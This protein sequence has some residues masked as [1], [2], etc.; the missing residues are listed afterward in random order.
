MLR[1]IPQTVEWRAVIENLKA[2][3]EGSLTK[4]RVARVLTERAME[5]R[6]KTGLNSDEPT[7]QTLAV[8]NT[9]QV[10][11]YR[12]GQKGHVK[13][14]CPGRHNGNR[15]ERKSDDTGGT[16]K[17][18]KFDRQKHGG[19]DEKPE[20]A[21]HM[22][23]S[24]RRGEWV[25][26]SG[27]PQWYT[28]DK[29]VFK[30]FER[31]S[32]QCTGVTGDR[33]AIEGVGSVMFRTKKTDGS[34]GSVLW[35]NVYYAPGFKANIMSTVATSQKGM[36]NH[37]VDKE[38]SCFTINGKEVMCAKLVGSHWEMQIEPIPAGSSINTIDE[39]INNNKLWH[40]RYGHLSEKTLGLTQ[41]HVRGLVLS[42]R[43][44]GKCHD[45]ITAKITRRSFPK[46]T[47][48]RERRP[49]D[50]I[51]MDIDVFNT[52]GRDSEK[53]I[54]FLTDDFSGYRFG[55]PITTRS[56]QVILDCLL[57][58]L[59]FMERQ[60]GHTLKAIRSDNAL[61]FSQGIFSTKIRQ[62]GIA[63]EFTLPYEHEQA[64]TAENT[65]RVIVDKART[66]L[67]SSNMETK[68]WPDA[69]RTSV[70]VANRS[71]HYGVKGIPYEQFTGRVADVR[72]LRV[73]GSWCWARRPAEHL[74]GS[75]KLEE[76][77]ILCRMLGYE[78]NGHSYRLLAIDSA[79]VISA[80][81]VI[82]DESAT[83]RPSGGVG[84]SDTPFVGEKQAAK[85]NVLFDMEAD[86]PDVEQ[87][88]NSNSDDS[89]SDAS[90]GNAGSDTDSEDTDDNDD[91]TAADA[92]NGG[93]SVGLRRSGRVSRP[94]GQ[95]W[96]TDTRNPVNYSFNVV[97]GNE[98]EVL[99]TAARDLEY[100]TLMEYNTWDLV[101]APPGRKIVGSKWVDSI[102]RDGT[103]K[104]RLVCQ[105]FSQVEGVDYFDTFSP[106]AKPTMV[107]MVFMLA[108]VHDLELDQIDVRAAYLNADIDVP[109]Y[110]RQP[111]GY[112]K[113]DLVCRLNKALYGTKQAGRAWAVKLK[114]FLEECGFRA[115]VY[116]PCCFTMQCTEGIIFMVVW[117]DDISVAYHMNCKR[118]YEIFRSKLRAKFQLKEM[119]PVQDYLGMEVVRKREAFEL[120]FNCSD[121]INRI[122]KQFDMEYCDTRRIPMA[123]GAQI[124]AQVD[125]EDVADK[126][127][128]SLVGSLLYPSQWCRPDLSYSVGALSQVMAGASKKQWD[129]GLDVV[130]YLKGA[131]DMELTYRRHDGQGM[132]VV[133]Y[134]D[135][136]F[137]NDKVSGKSVYGYVVYVGGNSVSWKSKKAQTTAT[138]TTIAELDAI[139]NCATE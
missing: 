26:D 25:M 10:I 72:M 30:T 119:G 11:C 106:V 7:V 61:E 112:E 113:G 131:K 29:S 17:F 28:W 49:L 134:A 59:P 84:I 47:A 108:A 36:L 120:R 130:R 31:I 12:C 23:S 50:L 137:A 100:K 45:C 82:F 74:T 132:D 110:M 93:E 124:G 87:G 123:A 38:T 67:L 122:L 129:M 121:N 109:I 99:R 91:D 117:V 95:W 138:S 75:H 58:I 42:S 118:E 8:S 9:R 107:R 16:G 21:F 77:G 127:Y 54:L 1:S 53:Y 63:H 73:F 89:F 69:V 80:T 39:D 27:A 68:F 19:W 34:F 65:N 79:K 94:V 98:N 6:S 103:Y 62:M 52:L 101:Q 97:N 37:Q 64:G 41:K 116:D 44:L 2:Q 133:A 85:P 78:Q 139:Y 35:S 13:R 96:M 4:E 102:K 15:A 14:E 57:N 70:F 83:S 22:G 48:P 18:S 66:I 71:W 115:S 20:Y 56:G 92:K 76:R 5:L 24:S 46:S 135:S 43:T 86:K 3:D 40:H 105:G 104:S 114:S 128:K 32:E 125:S 33:T 55:F 111:K 81:H 88:N 90:G 136:D 60:T 126:P 51:H